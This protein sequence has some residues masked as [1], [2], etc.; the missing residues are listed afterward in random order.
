MFFTQTL[1]R[2]AAQVLQGCPELIVQ[3]LMAGRHDLIPLAYAEPIGKIQG[4][5]EVKGRLWGYYYD[6][7]AQANY[8]LMAPLGYSLGEREVVIGDGLGPAAWARSGGNV[9]LL[10]L[11]RQARGFTIKGES[12]PETALCRLQISS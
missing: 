9:F 1:K 12:G 3:K 2:E 8:T 4:V 5:R 7:T 6:Q 11:R 10:V